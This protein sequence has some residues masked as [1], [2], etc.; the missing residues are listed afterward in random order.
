MPKPAKADLFGGDVTG[1]ACAEQ[2]D[3]SVQDGVTP[4][5]LVEIPQSSHGKSLAHLGW[6]SFK[7]GL[8]CRGGPDELT[9]LTLRHI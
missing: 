1:V 6:V 5:R 3:R 2:D 7:S 8:Q 4:L 9:D